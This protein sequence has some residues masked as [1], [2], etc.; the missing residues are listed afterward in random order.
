[1]ERIRDELSQ[2]PI[3]YKGC[4]VKE[5]LCEKWLGSMINP[6][7]VKESTLSTIAERK[8]RIFNI[9]NETVHIIEDCRFSK[10]GA[11]KSAKDIWELCIIPS[12]LSNSETFFIK[13]SKIQKS[14]EDFQ[15]KLYKGLLALPNSVPLPSIAY[16][17]D[18]M[19]MKYRVYSRIINFAKHIF[20]Q[21]QS[22]NLSKQVMTEQINNNWPGLYRLSLEFCNE[23]QIEGL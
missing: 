2:N 20:C 4:K 16:E 12:L 6:K 22:S 10:L 1:M 19:L 13:D 3:I 8:I 17:S 15:S 18:S 14:L 7:G 23:L 21:D 11:L 5:K 9:I